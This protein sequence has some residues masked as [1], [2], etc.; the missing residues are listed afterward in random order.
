MFPVVTVFLTISIAV[1]CILLLFTSNRIYSILYLIFIYMCVSLLFMY[2]GLTLL[3]MFYFL[4]YIGAVAVLF[5]FSVMILDLKG[6]AHERDYSF[7]INSCILV[8]L[9]GIHLYLF[10]LDIDVYNFEYQMGISEMLKIIGFL[11]FNYYSFTFSFVGLI[12][13]VAMLG[14]IFLTN[15]QKGFFMRKQEDPMYRTSSLYNFIVY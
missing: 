13:L 1:G 9:L 12:L 14:A 7:F 8:F 10:T 4:V 6:S 5:L 2:V 15:V 3:G 11:L